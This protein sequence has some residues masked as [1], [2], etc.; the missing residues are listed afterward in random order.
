MPERS[1]AG[2]IVDGKTQYLDSVFTQ[3]NELFS[4]I[5]AQLNT[6]DSTYIFLAPTNATWKQ[7]IEEYEPYFT[8]PPSY[9]DRDSMAYTQPRLAIINGTAFSRT[10]NTDATLPD[11]AMSESCIRNYTMRLASWGGLPFEYYEYRRPLD[12]PFGVLNQS[13]DDIVPC[14]NGQVHKATRW[15]I[16][17]LM[18]F[19]Q[20][21]II[22]AEGRNSIKETSKV[23]DK[24]DSVSTIDINQR[25]VN[26]DMRNFYGRIWDNAFVEF[27]PAFS[28][29][30][31]SVTFTL[32]NVLSNIG[33]DIYLVTVPAL[34]NDSNATAEQRVPTILRCTLKAPGRDAEVLGDT[35]TTKADSIDYLLLAED[36]KFDYCTYGVD[37]EDLQVTL[38]V[39]T[40]VS[41]AQQRN[42]QYT[43]TMRI[44]CI[45]LVP[46]E[47]LYVPEE[48]PYIWVM[49]HGFPSDNHPVG[50]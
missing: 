3:R 8:Y 33:Y 24:G 20:W 40:R 37:D 1:V 15:N 45:L 22:Q 9:K 19:H 11:S 32:R 44:D 26:S 10:F 2:S 21:R 27:T 14:S 31:H 36:Y 13:A 5:N 17:K 50:A 47:T 46:H 42:K 7:L 25:I 29:V 35:Y 12:S 28:N 48:V 41:N 18:S 49:P 30:N 43:R 16:D 6:E 23:V 4:Q 38:K 34:A 39:E